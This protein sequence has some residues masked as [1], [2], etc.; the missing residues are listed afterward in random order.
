[1][2]LGGTSAKWLFPLR[3]PLRQSFVAGVEVKATF[4]KLTQ[5]HANSGSALTRTL[6]IRRLA[7]HF[8]Y[9]TNTHCAILKLESSVYSSDTG[10]AHVSAAGMVTG[11]NSVQPDSRWRKSE[12]GAGSHAASAGHCRH[13]PCT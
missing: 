12:C 6:P 1:M 8:S 10:V 13:R 3:G 7:P 4:H 5:G 11:G 9:L 2:Y